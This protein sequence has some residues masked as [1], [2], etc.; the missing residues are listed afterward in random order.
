MGYA[1]KKR[2]LGCP[3]FVC[4]R[5]IYVLYSAAVDSFLLRFRLGWHGVLGGLAWQGEGLWGWRGDRRALQKGSK[6]AT[7]RA[8]QSNTELSHTAKRLYGT[9]P[10]CACVCVGFACIYI[11]RVCV[12]LFVCMYG[13]VQRTNS[14]LHTTHATAKIKLSLCLSRSLSLSRCASPCV[15][16]CLCLSPHHSLSLSR[17]LSL[18]GALSLS[19]TNC[20]CGRVQDKFSAKHSK[21]L[22]WARAGGVAGGGGAAGGLDRT[23]VCDWEFCKVVSSSLLMLLLLLLPLL[24]F[25]FLPLTRCDGRHTL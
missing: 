8:E 11:R 24:L 5:N 21:S 1:N 10:M 4:S 14:R 2:Q 3:M 17:R 9:A 18:C 13:R 22:R 25:S 15:C 12:C 7:S 16:Y 20:I 23:A 19:R 6:A